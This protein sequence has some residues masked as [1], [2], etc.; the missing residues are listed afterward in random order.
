M[1]HTTPARRG[2]V[3][4]LA[5]LMRI[6]V[7]GGDLGSLGTELVAR[8]QRDPDDAN[9]LMDL[10]TVLQLKGDRATAMA[11]QAHALAIQQRYSL[12]A[13]AAPSLRLLAIMGPGDIS[14]NTPLEFLVEGSDVTLEMLYTSVNSPLPRPLPEHDVL[15]VAACESDQNK[16]LLAHIKEQLSD[17]RG[18]ILNAPERIVRLSRD[19]SCALLRELP[20]ISMPVSA[21][22]DREVMIQLAVG[23]ADIGAHCTDAAF[24]IIARPVGSHAGKGLSRLDAPH[25]L[26]AYLEERPESEF[27]VSRF[28]DYRSADGQFRKYRLAVVR[29]EPFLCHL[30]ISEHWMIHYINAGMFESAHKRDE[31]AR[32]MARFDQD[33]AVLHAGAIA[34]LTSALGLDYVIVDCAETKDGE[35]LV[36]EVDSGAVVHAMDPIDKFPYKQEPMRRVREAFRK[37]LSE[38]R[39]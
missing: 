10:S 15:F 35:L 29:G 36:F 4:G 20:G 19:E 1:N 13:P 6:A 16:A 28:V 24:P 30:A 32:A 2:T 21:R 18:T 39:P 5:S 12:A 25:D 38:A 8:A 31:E 17:Y 23:N 33:F 22:V 7:S 11:V 34:A 14:S 37:M 3:D 26:I 27:Y 9:A